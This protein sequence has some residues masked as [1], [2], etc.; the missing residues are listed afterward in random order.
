MTQF[1]AEEIL[2]LGEKCDATNAVQHGNN[3]RVFDSPSRHLAN[4]SERDAPIFQK[5]QL[6]FGKVFV[7]K[8]QA[9]ANLE[10]FRTA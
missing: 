1:P 4:S 9:A 3:V 8:I 2:V 10:R 7:Q 5:R 6:I